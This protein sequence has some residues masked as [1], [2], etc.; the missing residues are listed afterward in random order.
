MWEYGTGLI[1]VFIF[2]ETFL[3]ASL[4][5]FF[6]EFSSLVSLILCTFL[7]YFCSLH[8]Q[9]NRPKPDRIASS[10]KMDRQQRKNER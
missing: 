4:Y 7:C 6:G 9:P 5:A 1:L 8:L 3:P 10:W 2:T